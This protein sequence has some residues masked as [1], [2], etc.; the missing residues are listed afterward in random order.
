MGFPVKEI[1]VSTDAR[2]NVVVTSVN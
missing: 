2:N 1:V